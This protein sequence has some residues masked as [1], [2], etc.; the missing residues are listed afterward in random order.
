MKKFRMKNITLFLLAIFT[1]GFCNAQDTLINGIKYS[2]PVSFTSQQNQNNM[3]K[4][5]GISKLRPGP[6]GNETAPAHIYRIC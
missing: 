3:M 2:K 6:S 5:L 1:A 4:Q